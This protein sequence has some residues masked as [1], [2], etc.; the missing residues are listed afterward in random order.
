[1]ID[2]LPPKAAVEN[3]PE[4]EL[5]AELARLLESPIFAQS[6][7]LERFLRFTVE[8]ALAGRADQ[9][10]EYVIGTE[11]YDRKPPYHP[12][13]DS[14]VRS[15]ARRLRAK[16]DE[17]YAAEGKDDPVFI[18]FRP[19]AYSPVFRRNPSPAGAQELFAKGA[20]VS[21]A[22]LSFSDLSGLPLSKLCAEGVTEELIH[23]LALTDGIRI[24]S[25]AS[26]SQ[27]AAEACDIP[28]MARRLGVLNIIE[29]TVREE[30]NRLR[31]TIR[32]LSADGFQTS[33]HRFETEANAE[34][35]FDVQVQIATAFISRVR[36]EQSLIRKR[37]AT[38]GA[39]TLAF[40]PLV[41]LAE[42]LLD[43]G[44][45]IHSALVKFEEAAQA[46]PM[47]RA[48]C[49]IAQCHIELM[50]RGNTSSALLSQAKSAA[51]RALELDRD[52]IDSHASMA[53]VQA[54]EWCWS[55]ARA[56]FQRALALGPHAG[57]A[58]GYGLLCAALGH[59]DEASHHIETAQR[60]DP[61]SFR[62][63]IAL[64]KFLYITRRYDEAIRRFSPP[65]IYGP[66]PVE[67]RLQLALIYATK[68]DFESARRLAE[69][70]RPESGAQPALMAAIC[71]ILALCG[72]TEQATRIAADL[73][74]LT[75]A[76]ISCYRKALLSLAFQDIGHALAFLEESAS[77]RECELL[78]LAT[79]PRFDPLRK[80]PRFIRLS[81]KVFP[82]E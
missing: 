37:K 32:I 28:E 1:M 42:S 31:I 51:Q 81:A 9:L 76:R 12:S 60:I 48:F 3:I 46:A 64:A 82:A 55:G 62:Q 73:K 14:I 7:R 30:H 50:L 41:V 67:V 17:Y 75:E 16:L 5:R 29:G 63:K 13:Q 74:L 47:P 2:S 39:L 45:D 38:A 52:M 61:F 11:V 43:E 22:V 78:W 36:P 10:K 79:D 44:S 80:E 65:L 49:G 20:G 57:A 71:E 34:L 26:V 27:C 19:G 56:S 40:Y 69:T 24:A 58:R 33:S 8:A 54:M 77:Q 15:E 18:N 59:F 53:A 23:A 21:V 25:R 35:L 72:D 6:E 70:V 4:S 66:H 68:E